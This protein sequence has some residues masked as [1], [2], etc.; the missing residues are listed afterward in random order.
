MLPTPI[1]QEEE[2]NEDE[3]EEPFEEEDSHNK[4]AD[5]NPVMNLLFMQSLKKSV[6][7][8]MEVI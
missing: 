3:A 7:L 5:G 2:P 8:Q 1:Y 6:I 4:E